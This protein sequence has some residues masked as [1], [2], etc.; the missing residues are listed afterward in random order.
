MVDGVG[1][2]S[3]STGGPQPAKPTENRKTDVVS[4]SISDARDALDEAEKWHEKTGGKKL[5]NDFLQMAKRR[6]TDATNALK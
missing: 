1:Y 4:E 6:L 3:K 5:C 2:A